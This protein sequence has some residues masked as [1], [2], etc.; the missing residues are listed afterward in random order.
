MIRSITLLRRET[1]LI[2]LLFLADTHVALFLLWC[3]H[4]FNVCFVMSTH[5]ST[6][7]ITPLVV[8]APEIIV[9]QSRTYSCSIQIHSPSPLAI[10]PALS[11]TFY[12][13]YREASGNKIWKSVSLYNRADHRVFGLDAA[14]MYDFVIMSCDS[15]G[16][17]QVSNMVT[18]RTEI[19]AY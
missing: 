18:L 16:E 9:G 10:N 19:S 11:L 8:A 2:V 6:M 15:N 12:L 5:C 17:C 3:Y 7:H 13:L 14:T 4:W 1:L